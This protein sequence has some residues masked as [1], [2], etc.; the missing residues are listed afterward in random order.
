VYRLLVR[1]FLVSGLS[2]D[3][4]YMDDLALALTQLGIEAH[5]LRSPRE[6]RGIDAWLADLAA[7]AG[8][9]GMWL[10]HSFGCQI[11]E[12]MAR[13]HPDLVQA[14][15]L[16]AAPRISEHPSTQLARLALDGV[17]REPVGLVARAL[18]D[19]IWRTGPR[20]AWAEARLS[21]RLMRER[22]GGLAVPALVVHGERDLLSDEQCARAAAKRLGA[23][24][25]IAR[26]AAHGLTYT[27]PGLVAQICDQ[28]LHDV[29]LR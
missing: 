5:T 10:G 1:A 28:W 26:G 14:A 3:P 18:R 23:D 13:E 20:D 8:K 17:L 21:G 15:V 25:H 11:V 22:E 6:L 7:Q 27:H 4:T 9:P 19:V 16:C 12:R 29:G 2:L 24:L